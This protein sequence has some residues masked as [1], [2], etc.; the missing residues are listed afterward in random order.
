M[1]IDIEMIYIGPFVR[2]NRRY[3]SILRKS[4]VSKIR[5]RPNR[6]ITT[7]LT[8][9]FISSRREFQWRKRRYDILVARYNHYNHEMAL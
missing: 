2:G 1:E 5:Y 7:F 8:Q 4:L 6:N 9:P 3:D